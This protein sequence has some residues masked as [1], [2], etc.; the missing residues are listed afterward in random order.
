MA[1]KILPNMDER[2]N[3]DDILI[4]VDGVDHTLALYDELSDVFQISFRNLATDPRILGEPPYGPND[5]IGKALG[6]DGR[7]ASDVIE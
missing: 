7:L 6:I 3:V 1:L 5:P 2:E 4:V